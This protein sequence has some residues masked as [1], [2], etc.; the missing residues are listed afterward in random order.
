M[1]RHP[2]VAYSRGVLD[3]EIPAGRLVRLAVE[4]H[5]DDL[6]HAGERGLAFDRASAEHVIQFFGFLRHSK[7]EWAGEP[8][9]LEGWQQFILWVLFGWKRADGLRRFRTAYVEVPRKNGKAL[10][11]D[12]PIPTPSGWVLHGDLSPGDKVF[13]PSG[14]PVRVLATTE[15]YEGLCYRVRFSDHTSVVAHENHEWDTERTWFTRRRRGPDN[16]PLPTVTTA[17]LRGTL[18]CGARQDLVHSIPVAQAL[19]LPERKLTVDPYVLGVWLGD[20]HSACARL[21]CYDA[22]IL[23]NL[24]RRG[25]S[26]ELASVEHLYLI[27]RGTLQ[28]RLRALGLLGDKHIPSVYLRASAEQRMALLRGLM[29]TDGY[30][31]RAGQNE[32]VLTN[33]RLFFDAVELMRSLGYKP[34]VKVDRAQLYGKDCGTRYRAQFWAYADRP[35]VLLS[36]KARRL[37]QKPGRR[38]RSRTRQVVSVQPIGRRLVNCIQVEGERY[39]AGQAMVPTHN[40]T[41]SAGIGLYLM[42]GDGEPGAEV[43]SAATKRDQARITHSE[44]TRMVKASPPLRRMIRA[45]KDNLHVPETACKYE[46]LGADVNGMDGLN[47]HGAII[48]ELHA[49]KTPAVVDVLETA[50]GA[51]RQP[52]IFEITTAGY[53]RTSICYEHH[54]YTRQVLE[55]TVDDDSWFGYIAGAD[56]GDDWKAEATWRKANPNWGVS[57]KPD[58]L[59]RKASKAVH[60][61]VAQNAFQRLHLN[62]WTQQSDRWIDVDLWDANGG[63]GFD[64]DSLAGRPCYGGLDLSSVSDLTAWVLVFPH[65]GDLD[66]VDI[67]AR[68]WCPESQLTNEANRYREQYQAWE[69]VGHLQATPGDAVDYSAIR[70]QV[71]AD[72]QRY[73]LV[74]VNVDRL[75]QG[76]QLSMELQDEGLTV[77]G[78]GQGFLS[79]AVPMREF[80]A[81]LLRHQLHHGGNPVLRWMAANVAVKQDAADNLKVDKAES[82]GRV[83][84][85]VALVMALDRAMRNQGQGGSVYETRGLTVL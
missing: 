65:E 23:Q 54:E 69:R 32:L 46:P 56:E 30:V 67:L 51:R 49:H 85:I 72:A 74:D 55:R 2:V 41:L 7:A 5:L 45:Y 64:E 34:T 48:D 26:V 35:A 63:P 50:T 61:P 15:P 6:E 37:K 60:M 4:R 77:F 33:G 81:R 73:A 8:F 9:V 58:D 16:G 24:V 76:Y 19:Q 25:C 52:L 80:E 84:G 40:S 1:S 13:S 47:I 12:T 20:G 28:K 75:F 11:I 36:R 57:V 59:A 44:A 66:E 83:D 31:S 70:R 3:G 27:G 22:E 38:Q 39:L 78:M 68:F 71:L 14:A 17:E 43:Y 42:V 62:V 21:T 29:D 18:R 79:M 82:Q 53:D 10:D